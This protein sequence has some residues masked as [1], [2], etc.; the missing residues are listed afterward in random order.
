[1]KISDQQIKEI[2]RNNGL[3]FAQLKAFIDVESSGSGF[4]PA[5]GKIIIQFEPSWF[6]RHEP[7]APS[8]KWSANGVERQAEEWIAFNDAWKISPESAMMSTSIGMPQIM[9]FHFYRLG[10][11]SVGEMWDDFKRGEYQQVLALVRFIKTDDRLYRALVTKDWHTVAT[12]YNGASYKKMAKKW[13]RE[14]YDVSLRK[15]Y[16]KWSK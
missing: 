13:G 5:T 4:D 6:K 16:E 8:G 2:A 10:Y 7:Y 9:G 3:T 12:I 14:P 1:M 11:K 15:A